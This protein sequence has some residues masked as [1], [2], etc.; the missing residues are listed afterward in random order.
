MINKDLLNYLGEKKKLIFIIVILNCLGLLLSVLTTGSFVLAIYYFVNKT[1]ATGAYVLLAGLG[2]GLLRILTAHYSSKLAVNLADYV[3]YKL[4]HETYEKYLA[5]DGKTP[6][7]TSE[8]AQLSTEGIE[9][10]RLY[11]SN[12]LP[13]FFYA[14]IAPIMLFIIIMFF[15][16]SVALLY[17]CCG[18]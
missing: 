16:W 7:T 5:L 9:Q 8:M 15:D 13:S 18:Y 4:R 2:F 17:L 1:Y 14:M 12:Y 3:T 10:L 6:F 11:Y